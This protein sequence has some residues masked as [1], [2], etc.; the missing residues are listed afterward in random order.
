MRLFYENESI[1]SFVIV[2]YFWRLVLKKIQRNIS[3]VLAATLITT[4]FTVGAF[5]DSLVKKESKH[6]VK[7]T[8]DRFEKIVKSKN[9]TVFARINHQAAAKKVG[10]DMNEAEVLIFGSPKLGTAIMKFDAAAGLDLPLRVVVYK[11]NDG[12]TWIAYHNPQS[13]KDSYDVAKSPAL[14]KAEGA[15][16]KMTGKAAE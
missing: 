2:I 12:K 15:V 14:A 4:L 3:F 13:L 7:D 10:M 6:G 8:M 9:L 5:G 11:G 1:D 16:G